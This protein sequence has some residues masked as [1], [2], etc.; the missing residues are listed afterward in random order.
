MPTTEAQ[1]AQSEVTTWTNTVAAATK[2]L[3]KFRNDLQKVQDDQ[4]KLAAQLQ[5]RE[6]AVAAARAALGAAEASTPSSTAAALLATET[7]KL[8]ALL[9]Q[10]VTLEAS[11][12]TLKA[13]VDGAGAHLAASKASLAAAQATLTAAT[14]AQATRARWLTA[15]RL[16]PLT[17][18]QAAAK[19]IVD[20]SGTTLLADAEKKF[21]DNTKAHIPDE[22]FDAASA[23][24]ATWWNRRG[25]ELAGAAAV[26]AALKTAFSTDGGKDGAA[27]EKRVA[28][29]A[30][31]AEAAGYLDAAVRFAEAKQTLDEL[32]ALAGQALSDDESTRAASGKPAAGVLTALGAV[33]TKQQAWDAADAAWE[34]AVRAA[35]AKNPLLTFDDVDGDATVSPLVSPRN[36]AKTELATAR[37]TLAPNAEAVHQWA[38]TLTDATWRRLHGFFWARRTLEALKAS[39]DSAT[40]ATKLETAED[41]WATAAL[42]AAARS[43]TLAALETDAATAAD[44]ARAA[45]GFSRTATFAGLRCD[46]LFDQ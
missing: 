39:A 15:L 4:A 36:T 13:K 27:L 18:V 10:R 35:F 22:L 2:V 41:A 45:A 31:A 11:E 5:T 30:A 17:T 6:A 38:I 25:T 34:A 14:E 32:V 37:A 8:R 7:A 42:A 46:T 12:L 1:Y 26:S 33:A 20:A 3:A 44:E 16:P 24:F 23:R 40:L 43:R 9:G 19:A 29:E 28:F 21:R